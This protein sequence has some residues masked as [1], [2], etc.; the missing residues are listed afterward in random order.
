[1]P[2]KK[3]LEIKVHRYEEML[4]HIFPDITHSC[5]LCGHDGEKDNYGLPERVFI[6]PSY[7]SSG[8]A[9]YTKSKDYDEPG[10]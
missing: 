8:F 2:T 1:M 5:F 6:C 10:Y 3:Q 4:R 7:G 9:I